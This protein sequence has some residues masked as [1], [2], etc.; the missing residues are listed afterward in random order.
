MRGPGL[1]ATFTGL[2]LHKEVRMKIN[3]VLL[4]AAF[5]ILS[6]APTLLFAA[7][8]TAWVRRYQAGASVLD[9]AIAL[10]VDAAGN[11]YVTGASDTLGQLDIVTIKYDYNGNLIWQARYDGPDGLDDIPCAIA[12]SGTGTKGTGIVHVT[13]TSQGSGTDAGP[14]WDIVTTEYRADSGTFVWS[15]RH[16]PYDSLNERAVGMALDSAGNSYVTG[17]CDRASDPSYT[18]IVTI[19]YD[20]LGDT[21]WTARFSHPDSLQNSAAAIVWSPNPS[22]DPGTGIVHVTG[23]SQGSGTDAANYDFAT[24]SYAAGSGSENWR[25]F[26][27]GSGYDDR[28]TALAIDAGNLGGVFV[29]GTSEVS[30]GSVDYLTVAYDSL[31]DTLWVRR[32]DGGYGDDTPNAIA[33]LSS[34][35][36]P[37]TGIVH[38]TGTSQGSGTDGGDLDYL[39]VS[40]GASGSVNWT[41]RYDGGYGNDKALAIAVSRPATDQTGIVHVTGT[42]QGSGTDGVGL[43]Y[44]T[45][46]YNASGTVLWS[47]R[48]DGSYGD[49]VAVA[50]GT[51]GAGNTYVTGHSLGSDATLDYLTI[52]YGALTEP[53]TGWGESESLPAGSRRAGVNKGAWLALCA[54]SGVIYAAKGY[55]STDFFKYS[56]LSNSW[57][58]M[59]SIPGDEAGSL[60]LPSKGCV[61]ASDGGAYVYMTKGNNTSGF[62]RYD[63]NRDSWTRKANVPLGSDGRKVKGGTD[64][65]S[66]RRGTPPNDTTWMYLLKGYGTGFYRYNTLSNQWDSTLASAPA[67]GGRAKY[68]QGSFLVYDGNNAIYAHQAKYNDGTS[69]YMFRY[70]L[71]SG[72]WSGALRGMPLAGREGGKEGRKKKSA[73]GAAGAWYAGGIYALKGGGTQGFFRYS[74]GTDSWTQLD[75]VPRYGTSHKKRG[76]K[77]GGDIV[78]YG[79]GVFYALKGNKTNELWRFVTDVGPLSPSVQTGSPGPMPGQLEECAIATNTVVS[80]FATLHLGVSRSGPAVLRVFDVMGRCVGTWRA[81]PR[82]GTDAVEL[83]LRNLSAGVYAIRLETQGLVTTHRIVVVR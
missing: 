21:T 24:V 44:Y 45:I 30:G 65:V 28:A 25:A 67:G 40:Y 10:A 2:A 23:T 35:T 56:P 77:S 48:Y 22:S 3:R 61:G 82:P 31:G 66:V 15:A 62:W 43:D 70:D 42:S 63:V 58:A 81:S 39:T 49:D 6:A 75:T 13:G 37:G 78:S 16:D 47:H 32:Y 1:P 83:D 72:T 80:G 41:A 60:K 19:G 64:I 54:N 53:V 18:D 57:S 36:D 34:A 52:K 9:S 33:V 38:V 46:A 29:T 8:D 79:G 4:S 76:V 27:D 73:D 26:L 50:V 68:D 69:H 20:S 7:G 55:K 74:P 71:A 14:D 11:V 59:R 51:D 17:T 12:I 5:I